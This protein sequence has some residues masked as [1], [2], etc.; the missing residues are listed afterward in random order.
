MDFFSYSKK[1]Y[2]FFSRN[3]SPE[4]KER[5]L[6]SFLRVEGWIFLRNWLTYLTQVVAAAAGWDNNYYYVEKQII[7]S[8][9]SEGERNFILKC[10]KS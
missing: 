4:N 1:Q 6:E 7:L 2:I 9:R 10:V 8:L 5:D 3:K